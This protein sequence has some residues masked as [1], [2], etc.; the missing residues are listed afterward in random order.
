M[1]DICNAMSSLNSLWTCAR[2]A[3]SKVIENKRNIKKF[4][5]EEKVIGTDICLC[6]FVCVYSIVG[7]PHS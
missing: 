5:Q 2:L 6:I 7:I 4:E 3:K 1:H